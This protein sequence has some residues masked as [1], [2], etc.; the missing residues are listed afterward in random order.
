MLGVGLPKQVDQY[1]GPGQPK[2]AAA[3]TPGPRVPV[4]ADSLLCADVAAHG[5]EAVSRARAGTRV[6]RNRHAQRA[7]RVALTGR[8]RHGLATMFEPPWRIATR[9]RQNRMLNPVSSIGLTHAGPTVPAP[10]AS[11]MPLRRFWA[12]LLLIVLAALGL[13]LVYV[14]ADRV[15][16]E[17][18]GDA[19]Y[20]SLQAQ[21]IADGRGF[22]CPI[23][24][25]S[26]CPAPVAV[27][28]HPPVTALALTPAA[29]A[30]GSQRAKL[31]TMVLFGTVGV[32][33]IGLLARQVGGDRV[34]LFAAAIAALYP[35]I[36]I[37]D[38]L[39]MSE[40]FAT[41]SVAVALLLVYRFSDRPTVG[42]S[43][44]IGALCGFMMLTRA[45]LGLFVPLV[46]VPAV[47]IVRAL[48]MRRRATLAGVLVLTTVATVSPWVIR[49]MARFEKPVF[50]STND[51]VTLAGANC[52]PVYSGKA[53]GLW[54]LCLGDPP[55]GD[56][57]V[58]DSYMRRQGL[59]YARNHFSRLPLVVAA[60]EGLIWGVF[61]PS[62]VVQYNRGEGREP[63]IAWLGVA[64][65]WLL[66]PL[67]FAGIFVLR[68][69]HVAVWPLLAQ[70]VI[71]TITAAAFYGLIRFRIPA[72]VAMTVLAACA[73]DALLEL[74]RADATDAPYAST[75]AARSDRPL[76][77]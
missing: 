3:E 7:V 30:F 51:G 44:L 26:V 35:N 19:L 29:W 31:L 11:A 65:Y 14:L 70:F 12:V 58:V 62:T 46:A 22:T 18:Q 50:L 2:T 36:W 1:P 34:G 59:K 60:R 33:A 24:A 10:T 15:G 57:S 23:V 5:R 32:L 13:R 20:Y 63:W 54:T 39:M 45:E 21:A 56:Q 28:D 73:L 64:T 75:L 47:M 9:P 71:V 16:A 6:A 17:L 72:E 25:P 27:A 67:A 68:R 69:R 43:A 40:T 61:R 49:N 76:H 77:V 8:R 42:Q 52:P 74:R 48:S 55:K 4:T 41:C 37:N 66:L 53:M 38:G